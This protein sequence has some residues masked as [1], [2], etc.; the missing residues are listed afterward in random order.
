MLIGWLH[1]PPACRR[2]ER[3]PHLPLREFSAAVPQAGTGLKVEAPAAVVVRMPATLLRLDESA[4]E[5]LR[6]VPRR[7][8]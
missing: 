3:W 2:A 5:G 8:V 4:C 1:A 6:R 7:L